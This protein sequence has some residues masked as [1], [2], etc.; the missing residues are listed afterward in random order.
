MKAKLM[1]DAMYYDGF[2]MWGYNPL[3]GA[4]RK[5]LLLPLDFDCRSV[6]QSEEISTIDEEF[7]ENDILSQKN[8]TK[9]SN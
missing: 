6:I 4:Y 5:D 1:G 9:S 3:K 8:Q 2:K 7:Q